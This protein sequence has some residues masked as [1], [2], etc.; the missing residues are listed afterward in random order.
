MRDLQYRAVVAGEVFV[1]KSV[2]LLAQAAERLGPRMGGINVSRHSLRALS[3]FCGHVLRVHVALEG[4]G[5]FKTTQCPSNVSSV[6]FRHDGLSE[7]ASLAR[8]QIS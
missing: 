1:W 8:E 6:T 2:L 7:S 5:L 4:C 3:L